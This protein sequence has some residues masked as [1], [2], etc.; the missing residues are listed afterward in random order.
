MT[1]KTNLTVAKVNASDISD[2]YDQVTRLK[3]ERDQM[4]PDKPKDRQFRIIT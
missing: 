3:W 2:I 1:G 4:I